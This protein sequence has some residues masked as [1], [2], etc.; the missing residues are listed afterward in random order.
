[1]Y[2]MH[3]SFLN[4][5]RVFVFSFTFDDVGYQKFAKVTTTFSFMKIYIYDVH[6]GPVATILHILSLV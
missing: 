5:C 2:L 1:M 3:N 6:R 4:Y